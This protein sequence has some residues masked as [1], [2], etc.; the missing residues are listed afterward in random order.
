MIN[1]RKCRDY[2]EHFLFI[3]NKKGE[4]CPFILNQP[5][6]IC[7]ETIAK[8]WRAGQPVRL[9]ILK[10]RQMGF[11]TVTGGIF[12]WATATKKHVRT[13]V[14]AHKDDSTNN[15]FSMYKRFYSWLPAPLRPMKRAYNG[16]EMIFDAPTH[17]AGKAE[18]LDSTIKCAT[19]GGEGV[20]RSDTLTNVHAS[21]F[22]FWPGDKENT[23][24]GIMQAVPMEP[25][26]IVVI[27][28]TANG[29]DAF[30]K[31]WDDAVE[32]QRAG[33][34]DS[35]TPI[36]FA[37]WQMK[38]YRRKVPPKFELTDEELQLKETY[39]LDDEQIAWRRWCIKINC[40]GDLDKFRQEYPASPDEAFIATGTCVFDK[41]MLVLRRAQVEKILPEYGEFQYDYDDTQPAGRKI[42][43]IRWVPAKKGNIR[44]YKHPEERVPYVAGGDTAGD[45]SD[46]FTGQM[47][48]NRTGRQVAV[49]QHTYSETYYTRQ[50]YCLG[51]YYNEALLGI[52]TNYSTYPQKE[53]ERLGYKNFYVREKVDEFT[54]KTEMSFGFRTTPRT[55]PLIIDE[56]KAVA[57]ADLQLIGD[58][59]TL[60]EMLTFIYNEDRRPE[61]E[62][63]EHDDLVMALAIAHHIRPQQRI[64]IPIKAA[65][66]SGGRWTSDMLADYHRA[67]PAMRKAMIQE[68]GEPR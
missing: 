35:W 21:E 4:K 31:R 28:S 50:M 47:L 67:S 49:L 7:Y 9:L 39:G 55:R 11:S 48:D 19:A 33:D 41:N 27:E 63:G 58:Y 62:V 26:T 32:G 2:I 29:Y 51:M 61:A 46:N 42:S 68:W 65:G 43:N 5:Q 1:I 12:F 20:G 15:L 8:Q 22:A 60:G 10:A 30:K 66:S 6:Q 45:G 37:W 36:F 40:G 57:N 18:G 38:E 17:L 25:G 23:L 54:G 44:I 64:S 14:I 52:E 56:L 24:L 59:A 34:P 13:L 53:L 3:R 16:R